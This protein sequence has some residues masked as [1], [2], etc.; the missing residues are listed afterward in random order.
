MKTT[1][2]RR[3]ALDGAFA[4]AQH[5][6][7]SCA[8]GGDITRQLSINCPA[9]LI[10]LGWTLLRFVLVA[11]FLAPSQARVSACRVNAGTHGR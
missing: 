7:V 10:H 5:F 8:A 1:L 3:E 2:N 6:S 11:V 9:H 4:C